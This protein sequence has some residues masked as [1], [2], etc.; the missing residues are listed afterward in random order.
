MAAHNGQPNPKVVFFLCGLISFNSGLVASAE[1]T[2][3][4]PASTQLFFP[5][6]NIE[7]DNVG[8]V[9]PLSIAGLRNLANFSVTQTTSLDVTNDGVPVERLDEYRV[10]SPVFGYTL[11]PSSSTRPKAIPEKRHGTIWSRNRTFPLC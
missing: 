5:I 2:I 4:I 9:P 3:A 6:L 7:E 8:V 11:P 10:I 1:R